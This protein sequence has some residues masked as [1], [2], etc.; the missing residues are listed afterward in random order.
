MP[1]RF[2]RLITTSIISQIF[3]LP[4]RTTT[5][6]D[7]PAILPPERVDL[8]QE[9]NLKSINLAIKRMLISMMMTKRMEMNNLCS[10]LL[11][12]SKSIVLLL[13][14]LMNWEQP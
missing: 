1:R 3:K 6:A 7:P 5:E 12:L 4:V 14:S 2:Q 13:K 10:Y 9:T 8:I 11:D